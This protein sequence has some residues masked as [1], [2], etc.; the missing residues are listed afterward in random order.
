M[1][2]VDFGAG[3]PPRYIEGFTSS[4]LDGCV[5]IMEAGGG[6][7]KMADAARWY[8]EHVSVVMCIDAAVMQGILKDPLLGKYRDVARAQE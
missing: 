4:N 7:G 3:V 8:D 6:G 2:K 1:N 5:V